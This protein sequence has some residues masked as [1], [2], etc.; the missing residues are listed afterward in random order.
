MAGRFHPKNTPGENLLALLRIVPWRRR[1][2]T[3]LLIVIGLPTFVYGIFIGRNVFFGATHFFY[4][5]SAPP[6]ASPTPQP[7]LLKLLPQVGSLL[8]TVQEGDSCDAILVY[9][10]RM[11]Q[12]GEVFS[13]VKPETVRALNAALGQ[14]CH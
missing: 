4:D 10:M 7:P 2:I 9:Q 3:V 6:V 1:L 12:A 13:D 11:N 8:Y 5:L 14:D